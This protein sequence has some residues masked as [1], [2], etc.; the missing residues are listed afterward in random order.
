M[1]PTVQDHV[2][3]LQSVNTCA[4]IDYYSI[5]Q[6]PQVQCLSFYTNVLT[7]VISHKH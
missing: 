4:E 3:Q 2:M 6:L 5:L 7:F 1:C